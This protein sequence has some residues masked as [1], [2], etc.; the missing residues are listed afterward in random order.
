MLS[1]VQVEVWVEGEV[2]LVLGV[3]LELGGYVWC[4][5][6]FLFDRLRYCG[7]WGW[8]HAVA[9]SVADA[10]E[11][12][13]VCFIFG[14]QV[15]QVHVEARDWAAVAAWLAKVVVWWEAGHLGVRARIRL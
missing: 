12:P 7:G 14:E 5:L 3:T 1:E 11:G 15:S 8:P 4:E 13:L 2:L 9:H 10:A 6:M